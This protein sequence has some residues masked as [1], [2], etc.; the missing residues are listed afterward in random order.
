MSRP[1]VTTTVERGLSPR[2]A[3]RPQAGGGHRG[4]RRFALPDLTHCK[5]KAPAP[6][7]ALV[8][9]RAAAHRRQYGAD[10]RD[11]AQAQQ[12]GAPHWRQPNC[13]KVCGTSAPQSQRVGHDDLRRHGDGT[14]GNQ[15]GGAWAGDQGHSFYR[16]RGRGAA[17]GRPP[18]E[19]CRP[20]APGPNVVMEARRLPVRGRIRHRPAAGRPRACCAGAWPPWWGRRRPAPV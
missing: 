16:I 20:G 10:A 9:S 14:S 4:E 15:H 2:D 1:V 18:T 13:S 3:Y 6:R 11:T 5:V 12:Q 19:S 17:G 8:P 7:G